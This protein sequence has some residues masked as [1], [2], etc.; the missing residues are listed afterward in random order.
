MAGLQEKGKTPGELGRVNQNAAPRSEG[1]LLIYCELLP[2]NFKMTFSP[3]LVWKKKK[4]KPTWGK[5][6]LAVA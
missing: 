3:D 1:F 6:I 2:L 5:N 4:K